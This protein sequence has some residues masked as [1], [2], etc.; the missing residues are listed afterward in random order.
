M[1]V[2]LLVELPDHARGGDLAGVSDRTLDR[3]A[4]WRGERGA[5][6][7]AFRAIFLAADGSFSAWD[8]HN[9]A[10]IRASDA[11]VE[12]MRSLRAGK[13]K[14]PPQPQ[15]PQ[16]VTSVRR[17][18]GERS[19]LRDGST[20]KSTS[21]VPGERGA[22]SGEARP[23]LPTQPPTN[24]RLDRAE[25]NPEVEAFLASLGIAKPSTLP[26]Q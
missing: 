2:G 7:A 12:R 10:A 25:P 22:P 5:F 8:R 6:A 16:Q 1:F 4:G 24:P 21:P 17:T 14:T 18:F 20:L 13:K 9:G 23:L 3:W 19:H 11:A 15:Q 26:P